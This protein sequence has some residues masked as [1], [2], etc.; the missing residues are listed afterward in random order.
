MLSAPILMSLRLIIWTCPFQLIQTQHF[1]K[2]FQE[3]VVFQD[4]VIQEYINV[5]RKHNLRI[6]RL[7]K[8]KVWMNVHVNYLLQV[9]LLK[10]VTKIC[11]N[12]IP[13]VCPVHPDS[14]TSGTAFSAAHLDRTRQ[15][16]EALWSRRRNGYTLPGGQRE[17]EWLKKDQRTPQKP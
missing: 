5:I 2:R 3:A 4:R 13:W 12:P 16:R 15:T 8:P 6:I 9:T 11:L 17:C 7:L 10:V 14:S 1:L